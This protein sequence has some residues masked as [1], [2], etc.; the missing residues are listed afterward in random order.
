MLG[1]L[2]IGLSMKAFLDVGEVEAL[3][4]LVT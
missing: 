4:Y 1:A 3:S 2:A